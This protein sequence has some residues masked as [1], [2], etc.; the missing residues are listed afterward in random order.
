MSSSN[1]SARDFSSTSHET[2][3][4]HYVPNPRDLSTSS[5]DDSAPSAPQ[6]QRRQRPEGAAAV[7]PSAA[8]RSQAG[9]SQ[10]PVAAQAAQ[11]AQPAQ[12]QRRA[13]SDEDDPDEPQ[14]L[15]RSDSE[16]SYD[17]DVSLI[18]EELIV[19]DES[20]FRRVNPVEPP[21]DP[22]PPPPE[23]PFTGRAAGV[24]EHFPRFASVMKA[25]K[26]FISDQLVTYIC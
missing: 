24:K 2:Q 1:S 23:I 20:D 9:P 3:D 5:S 25:I 22:G 17:S 13:S 7:V 19:Y 10:Q 11:A 14:L 18:D 15:Y 4:A 6:R 8:D 26:W 12:P 16:F 21:R